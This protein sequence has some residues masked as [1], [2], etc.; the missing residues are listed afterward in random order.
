MTTGSIGG[1]QKH[2]LYTMMEETWRQSLDVY[3]GLGGFISKDRPYLYAHPREWL[4]HTLTVADANG[5]KTS[6]VNPSPSLP[7]PKLQMRRKLA[8]YENVAET[9]LAQQLGALFLHDPSRTF[10]AKVTNP[11]VS[12]WWEDIDGANTSASDFMRRWWVSAAVM[13]H[14]VALVDKPASEAKTAA[15]VPLPII[16]AYSALDLIDWLVDDRGQLVAVKLLEAAPRTTFE[17]VSQ[18]VERVRIVT[19][20]EWA[21]Y[22]RGALVEGGEHGFGRLPVVMLY[23]KR[24]VLTPIIGKSVQGDPSLYIDLYNLTSEVRELLRNQ[25]FS[26]LNVPIGTESNA[27][28]DRE[29]GLIG[30]TTGTGNIMF[31]SQP[32]TYIS[33]S[34]DN[35]TVY[36]DHIDR[37]ARMIYRLTSSAWDSDSRDAESAYS[38]KLKRTEQ[39]QTLAKFAGE[40]QSAEMALLELVYRGLY[41]DRWEKQWQSDSPTVAYSTQFEPPDIESIAASVADTLAIDL[42]ETATKEVKKRFVRV[43]LRGVEPDT[44]IAIDKEIDGQEVLTAAERQQ[45]LMQAASARFGAAPEDETK[46]APEPPSEDDEKAA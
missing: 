5:I 16:R 4:D 10:A 34:S 18:P 33:P 3:E 2:P 45:Q 15:D 26:V 22:E 23:G 35:A 9:I 1:V 20:T 28:V 31:S 12:E 38:R 44:Q 11:R 17:T 29:K 30:Q 8:R 21:V 43:V 24:R 40:M 27:S 13:G 6:T 14:A 42:G 19:E 46:R 32:A 7:S 25:T 39:D 36:H 37:L 41:G